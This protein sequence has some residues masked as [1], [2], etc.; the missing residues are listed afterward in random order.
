MEI[1][2]TGHGVRQSLSPT[3]YP[4]G[5]LETVDSPVI[6]LKK[7]VLTLLVYCYSIVRVVIVYLRG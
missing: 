5:I 7:R 4:L 1:Y 3:A 2:Y 6:E